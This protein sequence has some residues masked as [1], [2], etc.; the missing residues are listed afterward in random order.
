VAYVSENITGGITLQDGGTL[1]DAS[2][3]KHFP[4]FRRTVIIIIIII[5]IIIT[6][7]TGPTALGGPW[8]PQ[9]NVASDLYPWHQTANFYNPVSS[10]L[11]LPRQFLQSSF[12]AS[13]S[14]PSIST[15][16]FPRVFLYPVNFHSP[17]SSRLPLPR[18]SIL[19]SVGL[20]LFDLQVLS[21]ISF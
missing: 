20:F 17:V 13:S 2:M 15:T 11:P 21:V 10:R 12:L 14:T 1:N 6:N 7:T 8:P 9:A 5:I 16:Q 18:Q 4:T 3:G 19:I